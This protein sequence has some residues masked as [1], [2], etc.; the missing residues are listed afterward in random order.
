MKIEMINKL[1]YLFIELLAGDMPIVL[2]MTIYRPDGYTGA[3]AYFPNGK[4]AGMFTKNKLMKE[5]RTFIIIPTRDDK[6][7]PED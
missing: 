5:S 6:C 4:L 1:R 2:N 7:N 3:L